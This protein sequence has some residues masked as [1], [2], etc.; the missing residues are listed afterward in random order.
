MIGSGYQHAFESES[1][2]SAFK[3]EA[4]E[5]GTPFVEVDPT[6]CEFIERE[7]DPCVKE[8]F[9][10]MVKTEQGTTALFPF[11]RLSHSFVIGGLNQKFDS[12]KEKAA[13]DNVRKLLRS[14][15]ERVLKYVDQ[16]NPKAINKARH[17]VRAL[18]T[19]LAACDQA[20]EMIDLLC[21]PFPA[22][23]H[24][25]NDSEANH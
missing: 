10:R 2:V 6:V 1:G 19:Q 11:Q 25:S 17:Y 12:K 8:M 3:L 16:G 5:R 9:S 22:R 15:K 14:L 20:D 23:G 7:T 18:D 4:D 13:N 24:K 21:T